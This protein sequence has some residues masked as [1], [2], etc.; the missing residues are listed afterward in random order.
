[1]F[2]GSIPLVRGAHEGADEGLDGLLLVHGKL[3]K[4]LGHRPGQLFLVDGLAALGPQ[5]KVALVLPQ[6][7]YVQLAQV[8]LGARKRRKK[9]Y[10]EKTRTKRN[11]KGEGA[12]GSGRKKSQCCQPQGGVIHS[13]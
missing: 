4:V 6:R 2:I 11:G 13:R 12:M 1:L 9:S 3:G 7:T 10:G 8:D 5:A